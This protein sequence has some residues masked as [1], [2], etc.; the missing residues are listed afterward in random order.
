M[1]TVTAKAW[2]TNPEWADESAL[3][4]PMSMHFTSIRID[5]KNHG[6]LEVGTAEITLTSTMTKKELVLSMLAEL[7]TK[8]IS[9]A[10]QPESLDD[11]EDVAKRGGGVAKQARLKLEAETGKKV[12]S[13]QNAKQLRLLGESQ[14]K[15]INSRTAK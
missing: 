1:T 15:K 6:W 7:S 11:H 2:I 8:E 10:L 12:V 14:S 13:P 4:D 5:M 3:E 9:E